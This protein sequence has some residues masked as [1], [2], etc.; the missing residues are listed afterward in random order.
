MALKLKDLF[1][2]PHMKDLKLVA[3]AT[4]MDRT[5]HWVHVVELPDVMHWILGGELL[6]M[7]GIGIRDNLA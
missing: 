1:Q 6:F 2:L 4:G 7:T 3:G 5:L